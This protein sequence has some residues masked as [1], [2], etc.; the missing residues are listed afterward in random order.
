M[1]S[2]DPNMQTSFVENGQLHL[3]CYAIDQKQFY[4]FSI[5]N[6]VNF[7]EVAY[8]MFNQWIPTSTNYFAFY[9]L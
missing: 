8:H 9:S 2:F 6:A 1:M 5:G 7:V 3:A 4:F